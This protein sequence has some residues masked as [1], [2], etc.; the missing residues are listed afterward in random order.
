MKQLNARALLKA[1]APSD[2][3]ILDACTRMGTPKG[4]KPAQLAA[5]YKGAVETMERFG[6]ATTGA[7][8]VGLVSRVD[9][10]ILEERGNARDRG[11]VTGEGTDIGYDK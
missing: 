1:N 7:E 3:E 2:A 9:R 5:L 11:T 8:L 4:R 10:L 6:S